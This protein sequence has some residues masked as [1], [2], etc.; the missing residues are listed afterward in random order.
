MKIIISQSRRKKPKAGCGKKQL[1]RIRIPAAAGWRA[2]EVGTVLSETDETIRVDFGGGT[3][4]G[5][6]RSLFTEELQ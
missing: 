5:Y 1:R 6:P 4:A 3:T 2:G